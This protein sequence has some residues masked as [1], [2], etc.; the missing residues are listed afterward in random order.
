MNKSEERIKT[1]TISNELRMVINVKLWASAFFLKT[2]YMSF[3]V[4]LLAT[5][6]DM[7]RVGVFAF[8]TL[9]FM[10]V[11][12]RYLCEERLLR[13]RGDVTMFDCITSWSV[14]YYYMSIWFTLALLAVFCD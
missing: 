2:L 4:A 13:S 14:A 8:L 12:A 7:N 1:K 9:M 3:A 5:G 6:L 11:D 10:Y